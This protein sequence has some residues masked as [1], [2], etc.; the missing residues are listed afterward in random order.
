MKASRSLSRTRIICLTHMITVHSPTIKSGIVGVDILALARIYTPPSGYVVTTSRLN[1]YAYT[2]GLQ[3]DTMH[4]THGTAD[5]HRHTHLGYQH[6]SA[7]THGTARSHR[8]TH[9]G[10]QQITQP[11]EWAMPVRQSN[12]LSMALCQPNAQPGVP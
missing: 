10:N 2:R 5:T 9:M 7:N 11:T 6:T 4:Y 3:L 12:L 8:L 1:R